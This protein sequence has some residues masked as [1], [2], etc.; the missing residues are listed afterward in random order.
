MDK[1]YLIAIYSHIMHRCTDGGDWE[2]GKGGGGEWIKSAAYFY[3]VINN[4]SVPP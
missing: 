4:K 3:R 1:R 2:G